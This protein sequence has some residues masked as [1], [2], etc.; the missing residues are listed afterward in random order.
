MGKPKF[1]RRLAFVILPSFYIVVVLL[2]SIFIIMLIDTHRNYSNQANYKFAQTSAQTM[3]SW[4]KLIEQQV[5]MELDRDEKFRK[6]LYETESGTEAFQFLKTQLSQTFNKVVQFNP[7]IDSIY[8]Y[9][10][11]DQTVLSSRSFR[12]LGEFGDKEFVSRLAAKALPELWSSVRTYNEYYPLVEYK[13]EGQ[14]VRVISYV[15]KVPLFMSKNGLLVININVNRLEALLRENAGDSVGYV[16]MVDSEGHI[17]AATTN[18]PG[19]AKVVSE[20]NSSVSGYFYES[21]WTSKDI[22]EEMYSFLNFWMAV[23]IA[24][25]LA[26]TIGML[27]LLRRFAHPIDS[28]INRLTSKRQFNGLDFEYLDNLMDE[29]IHQASEY[30]FA[31]NQYQDITRKQWLREILTG[32]R[33]I[34][35]EDWNARVHEEGVTQEWTTSQVMVFE[36]DRY[37]EFQEQYSPNDQSLF[38]F[39]IEQVVK[40]TISEDN[41]RIWMSWLSSEQLTVMAQGEMLEQAQRIKHWVR[42]HLPFTVSI[43][44]SGLVN[45]PSQIAESR[46]EALEL[47]SYKATQGIDRIFTAVPDS[48]GSQLE[49]L[50]VIESTSQAAYSLRMGTAGWREQ[51][52]QVFDT[53]ELSITSRSKLLTLF[54]YMN[55]CLS[56]VIKEGPESYRDTF[57]KRIEPHLINLL[58]RFETVQEYRDGWLKAVSALADELERLRSGNQKYEVFK[59]IEQ[60]MK[61]CFHDPDL[62]LAKIAE[63]FCMSNSH[64]SRLI[65]EATGINWTDYVT[66]LR[67]R[68]AKLLLSTTNKS[69]QEIGAEC[70]YLHHV[71]FGRV[72]KKQVGFAPG[73]YRKQA[74]LKKETAV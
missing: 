62:S 32:E 35:T 51:M 20:V 22:S 53:I 17:I 55:F 37:K 5:I 66:E 25:V 10:E 13:V 8:V 71:S 7:L 15:R 61:A 18:I 19:E 68:H 6:F 64:M 43:G 21:G 23:G 39:A 54:Q 28:L 36:I 52:T 1:T 74:V 42:L 50:N 59:Q 2:S 4:L 34:S 41:I 9:R 12:Q 27:W 38:K 70:G 67:V 73:D 56:K 49:L 30:H 26:I 60:Y 44:I 63:H 31:S 11:I 72:F 48:G 14:N 46:E 57:D 40:E 58:D 33:M 47:L 69:V 65:K 29:L 3:D 45:E 24:C 16:R